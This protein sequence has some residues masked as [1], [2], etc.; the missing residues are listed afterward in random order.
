VEPNDFESRG[1]YFEFGS[2]HRLSGS[3]VLHLDDGGAE[4]LP[5]AVAAAALVEIQKSISPTAAFFARLQNL[6]KSADPDSSINPLRPI[7]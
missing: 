3:G 6:E 7:C 4:V 5:I 1:L 2:L